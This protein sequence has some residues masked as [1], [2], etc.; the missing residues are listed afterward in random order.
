MKWF[1]KLFRGKFAKP[2]E[3]TLSK[4]ESKKNSFDF[5]NCFKRTVKASGSVSAPIRL[6]SEIFAVTTSRNFRSDS[7]DEFVYESNWVLL[8]REQ[9]EEPRFQQHI[10]RSDSLTSICHSISEN[11]LDIRRAEVVAQPPSCHCQHRYPADTQKS[12]KS[13]L[14]K[15][16]DSFGRIWRRLC[17]KIIQCFFKLKWTPKNDAD[18]IGS[19]TDSYLCR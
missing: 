5:L 10:A 7:L 6:P 11:S 2:S 3:Q 14:R 17:T 1:K 8:T 13:A 16:F 12:R 18:S 9:F 4:T 15:F 19:Y